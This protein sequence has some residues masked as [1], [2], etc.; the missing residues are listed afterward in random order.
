LEILGHGKPSY[1]TRESL[2]KDSVSEIRQATLSHEIAKRAEDNVIRDGNALPFG[3]Q[4]PAPEFGNHNSGIGPELSLL[5]CGHTPIFS[6]RFQA[7]R[8]SVW[9]KW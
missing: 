6:E 1:R 7:S 5:F 8:R 2:R 9:Y 3:E 4:H